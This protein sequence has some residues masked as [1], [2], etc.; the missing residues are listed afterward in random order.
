M[1]SHTIELTDEQMSVVEAQLKSGRYETV[2]DVIQDG[3]RLVVETEDDC[4]EES[5]WLF[6]AAKP[7]V[8]DIE[9]GRFVTLRSREEI[10]RFLED[11][12]A[13]VHAELE[14]ES[15]RA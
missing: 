9:A 3:L 1:G 7:G 14:A 13:G 15:R 2:S 6:E 12:R 10:R 5:D 11:V 8:E 4:A